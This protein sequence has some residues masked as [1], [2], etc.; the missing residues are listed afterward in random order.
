ML[1]LFFLCEGVDVAGEDDLWL[2]RNGSSCLPWLHVIMEVFSTARALVSLR[3]GW[4]Y[5]HTILTGPS[6]YF[7]FKLFSVYVSLED[8]AWKSSH[9]VTHHWRTGV[10]LAL[11][12]FL[13]LWTM[14][15][16]LVGRFLFLT[17]LKGYCRRHGVVERIHSWVILL[18]NAAMGNPGSYFS[19]HRESLA[20]HR[21]SMCSDRS[22]LRKK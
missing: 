3:M 13:D 14:K 18:C 7:F 19:S 8:L 15:N 9:M 5:F 1:W 6:V 22:C 12:P 10:N 11:F 4:K 16:C 21:E 2:P 20:T 17:F